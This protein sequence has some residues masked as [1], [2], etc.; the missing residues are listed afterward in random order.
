MG[1]HFYASTLFLKHQE[2]STQHETSLEVSPGSL[3]MNTSI[4]NT[5][6]TG[7]AKKKVSELLM[8]AAASFSSRRHGRPEVLGDRRVWVD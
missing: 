8:L 3:H 5:V 7:F 1:V 2:G 4:E 6:Y